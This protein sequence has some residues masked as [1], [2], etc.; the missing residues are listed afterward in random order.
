MKRNRKIKQPKP[1]SAQSIKA[2][3]RNARKRAPMLAAWDE[4]ER[5]RQAEHIRGIV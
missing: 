2:L 1:I 4:D 3:R 5:R